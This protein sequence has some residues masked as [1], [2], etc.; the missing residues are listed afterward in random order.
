MVNGN[1]LPFCA[2]PHAPGEPAS[3]PTGVKEVVILVANSGRRAYGSS[4]ANHIHP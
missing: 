2:L 1:R 4:G 3:F